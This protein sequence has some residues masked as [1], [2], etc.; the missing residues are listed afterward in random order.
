MCIRDRGDA[1]EGDGVSETVAFDGATQACVTSVPSSPV[2]AD[3]LT[4]RSRNWRPDQWK[5][6][7]VQTKGGSSGRFLITGN[8][9][10]TLYGDFTPGQAWQYVIYRPLAN[11]TYHW[12]RVDRIATADMDIR[13]LTVSVPHYF[14]A[15]NAAGR[16]YSFSPHTDGKDDQYRKRPD[17]GQYTIEI[18]AVVPQ[19]LDNFLNV[20]TMRDPGAPRPK[21][22]PIEGTNVAGVQVDDRFVVFAKGREPVSELSFAMPGTGEVEGLVANLPAGKAVRVDRSG[23][24]VRISTTGS[25][26]RQ[27]PV[28]EMGVA[29]ITLTH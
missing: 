18:E 16:L 22:T 8:D 17:L 12:K 7:M 14:D 26:G 11:T 20:I 13:A 3:S 9:A 28:S 15:V 10:Q 23:E 6:Y 5:D 27:V 19:H 29:R 21:V 24:R 4:D 2:A 1:Q 25:Q